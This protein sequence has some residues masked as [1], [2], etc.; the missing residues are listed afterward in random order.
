MRIK[1]LELGKRKK[2][3]WSKKTA[4][5]ILTFTSTARLPN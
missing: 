2:K 5:G 4:E 3:V 1:K